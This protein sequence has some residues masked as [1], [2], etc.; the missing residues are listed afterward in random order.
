MDIYV[1]L[2][3][4]VKKAHPSLFQFLSFIQR[5]QHTNETLRVQYA[6]GGKRPS[7]RRKYRAIDNRLRVLH[8]RLLGEEIQMM[9]YSDLC[10]ALLH[11]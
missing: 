7:K 11:L 4:L 6:G 9:E 8:D 3:G 10:G 1:H 2:Q 5:E